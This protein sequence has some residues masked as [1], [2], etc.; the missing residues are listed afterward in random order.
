MI[1]SC[2]MV[3]W[4]QYWPENGNSLVQI[5]EVMLANKLHF[6]CNVYFI[7]ARHKKFLRQT[8]IHSNVCFWM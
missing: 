1:K 2:S 7:G 3:L 4:W 6:D 8:T 5:S